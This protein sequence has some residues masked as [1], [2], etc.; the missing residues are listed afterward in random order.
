ME[1]ADILSTCKEGELSAGPPHWDLY[2]V[3]ACLRVISQSPIFLAGICTEGGWSNEE[4]GSFDSKSFG[5]KVGE[6]ILSVV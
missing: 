3:F 4:E 6:V 2:P 1:R 5:T